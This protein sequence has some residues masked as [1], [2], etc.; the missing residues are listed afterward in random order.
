MPYR[1]SRKP[2]TDIAAELGATYVVESALRVEGARLRVTSRLLRAADHAQLWS[3]TFDGEPASVL[4]FERELSEAL[5]AQIRLTLSV[6]RMA[7][8]ARRH[9]QDA[10][11][12]HL[13]LEGRY[14]WN[15]L[16]R[17]TTRR[18]IECFSRATAKDPGYALAWAGIADAYATS[19]ITGDASPALV[20]PL[21]RDAATRA[22]AADAQLAAAHAS[23]GAVQFFLTWQWQEA[24]SHHRRALDLD[25]GY[26]QGYR[27]L[28]ILLSHLC[29][30]D[31]AL[32]VIRRA[33]EL[34][35]LYAMHHAL[36][37]QIAF[38]ARR[39]DQAVQF[40]R[41]A[42]A[43]D[44]GFWI[45]HF[46]LGQVLAQE[47]AIDEA[48]IVLEHAGRLAGN[49]KAIALRGYLLARTGRIAEARGVL[50]ALEA[51][52][53]ERYVPPYALALLHLGLGD[54]DAAFS[55]LERA[56]EARDI[57]LIFLPIDPKWDDVRADARFEA[58]IRRCGF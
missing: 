15:Q 33:R 37:A 5:A 54:V 48:L 36:S 12:Y 10:D 19:P 35:P 20:G 34:D 57:H 47:G 4:E 2:L 40:A 45:G 1:G 28:G 3:R 27:M 38:A 14:Y 21:A 43:I 52:G 58:L 41:Q 8:I 56:F 51:I 18:A 25:P 22:L 6:G 17:D 30:H 55:W 16:T 29:R 9:S 49:S 50:G 24:E 13:Y 11:A 32:E 53:R 7:A 26:A 46:Q 44:A 39:F 23:I 31:E 42:I